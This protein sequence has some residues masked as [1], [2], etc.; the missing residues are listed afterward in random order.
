MAGNVYI[1][2]AAD[3]DV[4]LTVNGGIHDLPQGQDKIVTPSSGDPYIKFTP[5]QAT[6]ER[7]GEST[8]NEGRFK[9]DSDENCTTELLIE[10]PGQ[11]NGPYQIE[12]KPSQ[13]AVNR[14]LQMTVYYTGAVLSF[15][16][17]VIW[18]SVDAVN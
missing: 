1:Y 12:I 15:R 13:Y 8:A 11:T 18:S 5:S 17:K 3:Q 7:N 9:S 4:T 2:N 6:I 16:G 10:T 14:D